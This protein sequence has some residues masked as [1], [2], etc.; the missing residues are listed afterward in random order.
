MI[1]T[2]VPVAP[3]LRIGILGAAAIAPTAIITPARERDDVIVAAVAAAR[4][5]AAQA[6]ARTHGVA[7]S[8]ADYDSLLSRDDIDLIYI[9]TAAASHGELTCAAL[10][11]GHHVLVEKPAAMTGEE[12]ARM[13][14]TARRA[15]RRLI[16][17]FHYAHHPMFRAMLDAVHGGDLGELVELRAEVHDP[18]PF[19]TG[20][21]LHELGLGGGALRHAGCYPLHAMRQLAGAEPAVRSAT[22]TLN[23]TGTDTATTAELS[24]GD[25]AATFVASF[26]DDGRVGNRLV[27]IGTRGRLEVENFIAPHL[28]ASLAVVTADGRRREVAIAGATSYSHQLDAVVHA[29]ASG[30]A[31]RTEGSDIVANA[32]AI[33]AILNAAGIHAG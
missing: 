24:F 6:F 7:A 1:E 5:G 10:E 31:V 33:E 26:G 18:R 28:G 2:A 4:P 14:A 22:S 23:P 9:A 17:A 27:A 12:A 11:A 21:V 20:S 32:A 8:H 30:E 3:P 19:A 16:E 15:G 25:V 13:T 29:I